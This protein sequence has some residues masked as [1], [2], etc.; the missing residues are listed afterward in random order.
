MESRLE[1]NLSDENIVLSSRDK[2]ADVYFFNAASCRWTVVK[3]DALEP[4]KVVLD[5]FGTRLNG[6]GDVFTALYRH[7]DQLFFR[8]GLLLIILPDSTVTSW[9]SSDN[10]AVLEFANGISLEFNYEIPEDALNAGNI[11]LDPTPFV[12]ADFFDFFLYIHHVLSDPDLRHSYGREFP[13][14]MEFG[15]KNKQAPSKCG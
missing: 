4:N 1:H 9:K 3:E 15:L 7:N 11:E 5:G 8:H 2:Y 13:G 6:Y 12:E 10:R 14:R